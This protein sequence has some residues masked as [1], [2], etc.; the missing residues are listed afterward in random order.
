MSP[1]P[2]SGTKRISAAVLTNAGSTV[3]E[4]ST[5]IAVAVAFRIRGAGPVGDLAVL[6]AAA[7]VGRPTR[8]RRLLQSP[9]S[10]SPSSNISRSACASPFNVQTRWTLATPVSSK[11]GRGR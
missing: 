2:A 3:K 4:F 7:H 11:R 8:R 6:P 5:R 9:C 1:P 10:L